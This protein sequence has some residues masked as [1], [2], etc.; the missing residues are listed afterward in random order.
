MIESTREII[1]IE[2]EGKLNKFTGKTSAKSFRSWLESRI[3]IYS[4]RNNEEYRQVFMEILR[5]YNHFEKEK[6]VEAEVDSW[7]GHSSFEVIK[8]LDRLIIIKYQKPDKFSEPKEVRTE[9]PKEEIVA[10]IDSIKE[11]G[12]SGEEIKTKDLAF[13]FCYRM[14]YNDTLNGE[15]WK[16]FFSNRK[17]HNRFTLLLGALDKL[18]FIKYLGGKTKL[19]DNKLNIQL[20]LE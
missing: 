12:A 3:G 4:R 13:K 14:G 20:V 16:N 18:G 5:A 19:L 9:I 8:G 2:K 7:H 11:L 10:T 1:K 15:F 6:I 17:L